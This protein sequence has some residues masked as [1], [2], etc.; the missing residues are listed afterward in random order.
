[1][2][3]LCV[4]CVVCVAQNWRCKETG[5]VELVRRSRHCLMAQAVYRSY[6]SPLTLE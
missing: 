4:V 3:I 2:H 6:V 5:G 1:M